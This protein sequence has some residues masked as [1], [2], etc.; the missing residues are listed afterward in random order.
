MVNVSPAIFGFRIWSHDISQAYLQSSE[1]LQRKVYLKP[2][3]EFKLSEDKLLELR[4]P[5]YGLSDS[6]DY[7]NYT[8]SKHLEKDLNMTPT[9]G[10]MSLF[11]KC[12]DN[13][14]A[15]LIGTYVDDSLICGNKEFEDLSKITLAKFESRER[16]YDNTKFAGFQ[17][18]T[19]SSGFE[20]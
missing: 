15:G 19:M 5:L 14:L 17:V 2:S 10:D 18:K 6:G 11:S 20:L 1:L 12:I 3:K 13:K 9:V 4:K 16:D 8:M 7:W